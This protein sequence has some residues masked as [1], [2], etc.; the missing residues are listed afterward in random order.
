MLNVNRFSQVNRKFKSSR[1]EKGLAYVAILI[2]V[3]IMSTL[4]LSFLYKAATLSKAT[5][6][7]LPG[8]EAEYLAESAANHAMWGLLNVPGFAPANN[9]YYMHSFA[10]WTLRLQGTKTHSDHLCHRCNNRCH[11]R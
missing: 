9:I 7:R 4:G 5:S 6:N 1:R 2:L 8:M 11:G 3:A 10:K